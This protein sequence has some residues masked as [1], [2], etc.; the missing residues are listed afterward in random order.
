MSPLLEVVGLSKAFPIRGGLFGR[1]AGHVKAVNGVSFALARGEAFG[2]AGESGSGKS[3]IAR[4]ILG[5]AEPSAGAILF[6]GRDLAGQAGASGRIGPVQMVFQNPGSS[7][8]PRRSIGQSMAVPLKARG[9]N[10]NEI[11]ERVARLLEMVQLPADFASRYPHELSGGQK[12]RVAIARAIAA[13]PK[14]I[15]LDEPT[16]A[17]DVSVQAKIIDLLNDLGR[18][19]GLTYLFISHD[20]SLMRNFVDRVGILYLGR[21]VE[22]GPAQSLF[23]APAHPYTRSLIAAVPVVS[24]EEAALKPNEP[25]LEGEIPSPANL[26]AGCAFHTRCPHAFAPCA[27]ELPDAVQLDAEHFAGCH[28]LAPGASTRGLTDRRTPKARSAG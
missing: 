7:L 10:R 22:V 20:L 2:L 17:L 19:L 1:A 27:I 18:S 28:L 16:S 5:L 6:D 11:A 25:A 15:V 13:E 8:N 12:Q 23:E 9:L 4:M 26:P 3:T 14:L 24:D 21:L